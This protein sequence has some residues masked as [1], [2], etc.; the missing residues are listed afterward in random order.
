MY[1]SRQVI[2]PEKE[3]LYHIAG[4]APDPSGAEPELRGHQSSLDLTRSALAHPLIRWRDR[5]I[6]A[7]LYEMDSKLVLHIICPKCSTPE[8]P[9]ALWVRQGQKDILWRPETGELSVEAF[10]CTWELPEGRRQEFGLGLCRWR[11]AIE[12]NFA[13][14]V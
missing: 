4:E 3:S 6:E 1:M 5:V 10:S 2:D 9:H 8:V 14:D 13:R 12:K 11:V 7:D